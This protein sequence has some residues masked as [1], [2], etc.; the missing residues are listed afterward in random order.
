MHKAVS[1]AVTNPFLR[2]LE[3]LLATF[4]LHPVLDIVLES[5]K[6]ADTGGY[7]PSEDVIVLSSRSSWVSG[8]LR[9]LAFGAARDR[10][11]NLD[12][13]CHGHLLPACSRSSG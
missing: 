11:R 7:L 2:P 3:W 6:F 9:P 8:L 13:L 4:E 1:E 10:W 12:R 5:P